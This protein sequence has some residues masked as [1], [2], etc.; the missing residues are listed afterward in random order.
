[1]KH[2]SMHI[3]CRNK[4]FIVQF[5]S[6]TFSKY[7]YQKAQYDVI[8]SS[9]SNTLT[10]TREWSKALELI[11]NIDKIYRLLNQPFVPLNERNN[12]IKCYWKYFFILY[13]M[14]IIGRHKH[15][16]YINESKYKKKIF[17]K[18]EVIRLWFAL[19]PLLIWFSIEQN[20]QYSTPVSLCAYIIQSIPIYQFDNGFI[21]I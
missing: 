3:C 21:S 2:V 8:I 14:V 7:D 19:G 4:Q 9:T 6:V 13:F 17:V 20:E 5:Y 11:K 10:M 12:K 18:T 15:I 16:F 1:M